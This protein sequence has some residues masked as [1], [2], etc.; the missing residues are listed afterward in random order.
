[1]PDEDDDFEIELDWEE[2]PVPEEPAVAKH[3]VGDKVV[4]VG[5][6]LPGGDRRAVSV[7]QIEKVIDWKTVSPLPMQTGTAYVVKHLW[8]ESL[9]MPVTKKKK[10]KGEELTV[11]VDGMYYVD[12]RDIHPLQNERS[13]TSICKRL[14]SSKGRKK[15]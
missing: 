9:A 11:M 5:S 6:Y 2:A 3:K 10:V 13:V 15:A 1:M 12:K 7:V 4:A 14:F 8:G